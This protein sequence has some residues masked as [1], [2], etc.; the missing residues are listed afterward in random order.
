LHEYIA[1]IIEPVANGSIV[2]E[3]RRRHVRQIDI[4]H[5]PNHCGLATV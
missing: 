2:L 5:S 1:P 4:F 3:V